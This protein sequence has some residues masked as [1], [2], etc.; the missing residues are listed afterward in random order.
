M[1]LYGP[2]SSTPS[3]NSNDN[4]QSFEFGPPS[5]NNNTGSTTTNAPLL[6]QQ[7]P[8]SLQQQ[9]L[10][11]PLPSSYMPI[12]PRNQY[13]LTS[14]SSPFLQ[15]NNQVFVFTTQLA[16]E[17]AEAVLKN[18]YPTILEYHKS[19]PS[20]AQ[21]LNVSETKNYFSLNC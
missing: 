4:N 8:P 10:P 9:N 21:Y 17:A 19:L 6:A 5:N 13:T 3:R 2:P 7:T 16:N 1:V 12:S 18:E 11:P 15:A 20:T 14:D